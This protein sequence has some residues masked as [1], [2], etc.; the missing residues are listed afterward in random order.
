MNSTGSFPVLGRLLNSSVCNCTDLTT[1]PTSAPNALSQGSAA[2]IVIALLFGCMTQLPGSLIT[3]E[4]N[5]FW[6][7]SPLL[8]IGETLAIFV[9]VIG[10]VFNSLG[11]R[12]RRLLPESSAWH[13]DRME[14]QGMCSIKVKAYVLL[15]ERLG[16]SR[17]YNYWL[18]QQWKQAAPTIEDIASLL[19]EVS[20]LERGSTLRPVVIVPMVLQFLK[21]IFIEGDWMQIKMLPYIYFWSWFS[22]EFL[23]LM[24]HGENLNEKDMLEAERLLL[25]AWHRRR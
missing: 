5:R 8:C 2:F 18:K 23:L 1:D 21:T 11:T 16:N 9:R 13:L 17:K 4:A 15:A 6:R 24:V 14:R 19:E 20:N 10:P 22:V 7:V 3:G 25:I 12:V